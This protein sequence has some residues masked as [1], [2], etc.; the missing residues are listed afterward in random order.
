MLGVRIATFLRANGWVLNLVF[1]VLAAYFV[2]GAVNAVLAQNIRVVPN[3][4]DKIEFRST[5]TINTSSRRSIINIAQRNL[6]SIKREN[7][8]PTP[9][10]VAATTAN[11]ND[12]RSCTMSMKV[13]ATLV[14]DNAPEWSMAVLFVNN[15]ADVYS[16]NE[17]T[18]KIGGDDT[19]VSIED[20]AVVVQRRD[21]YERCYAEGEEAS[22]SKTPSISSTGVIEQESSNPEITG[23][24]KRS[25]TEYTIERNEVDK[26]MNNLS[27]VATQAR[28]VP[29]FKNGKANGFKL[30]S[31]KPG[32][33]YEKIGLINGDV[34]Q[35][36]NGYEMSS[37][38]KALE[39]YQKLKEA[40]SVSIELQRRGRDMTMN[41][42]ID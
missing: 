31:I 40:S 12:I 26:A 11:P 21:H 9:K 18:N 1:I 3:A 10:V 8:S 5:K 33:I 13:R 41:Y 39:I 36:I 34:I 37:P 15:E 38:D 25:D 28:I 42:S 7:L 19:L 16:I 29:N 14:A 22:A 35:K 17:G 32:S 23:V 6:F 4:N 2:A 20:R 24:I 30:F 27:Q